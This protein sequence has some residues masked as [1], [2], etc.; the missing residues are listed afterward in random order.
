M[1][2]QVRIDRRV[3]YSF[4]LIMTV[5]NAVVF[6]I[7]WKEIMA[8]K[9]DFPVFY[10]SAQMVREGQSSH[11]YDFDAENSFVHRVSEKSR[12][13]NNHLPY[14]LLIFVPFT[15]L[16]FGTAQVLWILLSLAMLVAVAAML[17]NIWRN[18]SSGS[19][20][21]LTITGFFPVWYCLLQGQDS[22]MLLFLLALSY[23]CW[24]R[25]QDDAAGFVL[26]L[27]LFR[28][29]LVLPFAFVALLGGKWKFVRGFVPGAIVVVGLS[30]WVVGLH[31]MAEYARV[32]ISQGT[33]GSAGAL[34]KQWQVDPSLMPTLRGLL[35]V[36]L[37]SSMP[38]IVRTLLLFAGLSFG[39][40]WAAKGIREAQD[41][42]TFDLAFAVTAAVVV[43][44]SFH[45]FLHD[46]SL[47]ILPLLVAGNA[48]LSSVRV[49]KTGQYLVVTMAFLLFLT[50]LYQVLLLTHKVGLLALLLIGALWL[51]SRW[52]I[53]AARVFEADQDPILCGVL[54]AQVER[55][56]S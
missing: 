45:S 37:P 53:G 18:S 4:M 23:W 17:H 38:G 15:H 33:G 55:L 47:L 19:L 36:S 48:V 40:L 6:F 49:A 50:P 13:P 22:I 8:G 7:P 29:Q 43:L 34:A 31:G 3:L 41:E 30:A 24:K 25:G 2:N 11:L 1:L 12:A 9:N 44:I 32:L 35:W 54:L 16:Q 28:P 42:A 26:A 56:Q 52:D 27:G 46:F 10:S 5:M 20:T 51:M 39:L 14:E 21:F